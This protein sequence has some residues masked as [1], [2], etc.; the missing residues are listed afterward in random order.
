MRILRW[1]SKLRARYIGMIGSKRKVI[2]FSRSAS[3]RPAGP[4]FRPGS[5][6]PSDSISAPSRRK[7][8]RSLSRE[9]IASPPRRRRRTSHELVQANAARV[10]PRGGLAAEALEDGRTEPLMFNLQFPLP[11]ASRWFPIG[12]SKSAIQQS[13]CPAPSF[14]A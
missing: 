2:E 6:P 14:A 11:I 7:R 4:S 12:N 1:A 5:R 13:L 10:A 9:L 3:G 8:S